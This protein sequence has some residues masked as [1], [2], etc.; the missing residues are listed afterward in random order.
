MATPKE[1]I[2]RILNAQ[3]GAKVPNLLARNTIDVNNGGAIPGRGIG[4]DIVKGVNLVG[5]IPGTLAQL[6]PQELGRGAGKVAADITD[7]V[8]GGPGQRLLGS[9]LQAARPGLVAFNEGFTGRTAGQP[10]AGPDTVQPTRLGAV[11]TPQATQVQE[12]VRAAVAQP[13]PAFA[14]QPAARDSAQGFL[15]TVAG[16]RQS[17]IN[18]GGIDVIRGMQTS[19]D[20]PLQSKFGF[21]STPT[22]QL[23]PG[24]FLGARRISEAGGSPAVAAAALQ[25][26]ATERSAGIRAGA[27]IEAARLRAEALGLGAVG[28]PPTTDAGIVEQINFRLASGTDANG[29]PL[30]PEDRAVLLSNKKQIQQTNPSLAFQ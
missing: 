12:Q 24:G 19:I 16:N 26:G 17:L 9:A 28:K 10:A 18:A 8:T 20:T 11:E 2:D 23:S 6:T 7:V 1:E 3:G 14:R 22:S 25:A 4:A 5:K 30:T 27:A 29:N 15:D 21:T 13:Q